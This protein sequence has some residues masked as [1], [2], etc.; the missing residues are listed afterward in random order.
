MFIDA[1]EKGLATGGW[2]IGLLSSLGL[3]TLVVYILAT[4][5]TYVFSGKEEK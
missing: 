3:F 5:L 2:V 4:A 1:L